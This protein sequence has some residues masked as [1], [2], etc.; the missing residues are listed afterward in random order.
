MSPQGK[1][2]TRS[3]ITLH[4]VV[5]GES[6]GNV[7]TVKYFGC[8]TGENNRIDKLNCQMLQHPTKFCCFSIVHQ[9]KSKPAPPDRFETKQLQLWSNVATILLNV[10]NDKF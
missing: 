10:T 5:I 8:T 6:I 1:H 4:W 3:R 9:E 7:Q 2:P